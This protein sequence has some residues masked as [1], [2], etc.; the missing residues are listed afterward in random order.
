[1]LCTINL[2]FV[3]PYSLDPILRAGDR[4]ITLQVLAW[5]AAKHELYVCPRGEAQ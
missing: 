1:M 4:I 2:C 5:Y 3:P